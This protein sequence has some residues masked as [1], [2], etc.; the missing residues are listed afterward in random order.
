VRSVHIRRFALPALVALVG[1][2]AG[3][4]GSSSPPKPAASATD[5]PE[6]THISVALLPTPDA[7]P[8][9]IAIHKGFFSQVGLTVTPEIVQ[10]SAA[11]TPDLVKGKVDFAS[12]NY[13]ST[14]EIEQNSGIS[15]RV[16]APGTEAAP[17]TFDLLVP[18]DSKITSVADL[19]GKSIAAPTASGAIGNLLVEAALKSAGVAPG[20]VKFV[21][22]PFPDMQEALTKGQVDA[23]APTEPFVTAIKGTIG[24]RSVADLTGGSMTGFAISGWGTTAQYASK[25]PKTV[26]AFQKALAKA[27]QLAATNR[28]LVEQTLPSYTTIKPKVASLI[29]LS[30]FPT[31]LTAPP[32]QQVADT[33][34]QLGFLHK[35]L[36][37]SPMILDAPS[38]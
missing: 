20:Q 30:T 17:N 8:L 21:A 4:C 6:K 12:L 36:D 33:M 25:Y 9:F 10:A 31:T 5:K 28:T 16:V 3:A 15:F 26:A 22:I 24:A 14:F 2:L 34:L 27:Q 37:V 23:A 11:V 7:A 13:V 29:T 19:K 32:L 18:K 38:S 35:K 1:L